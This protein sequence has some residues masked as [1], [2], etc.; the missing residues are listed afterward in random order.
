MTYDYDFVR[1]AGLRESIPSLAEIRKI[2]STIK[3]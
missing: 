1:P 3:D 2:D